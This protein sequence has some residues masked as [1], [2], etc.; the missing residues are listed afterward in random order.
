MKKK[1]LKTSSNLEAYTLWTNRLYAFVSNEIV[2]LIDD[3][4]K[5][6]KTIEY[7]I[8]CA[9]ECFN[10]GNYNSCYF[11]ISKYRLHIQIIIIII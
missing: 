5:R 6:V 2:K 4:K 7:F 11:I 3:S 1:Y 9:D 10:I 8:K